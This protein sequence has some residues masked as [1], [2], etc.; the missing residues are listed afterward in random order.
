[1]QSMSLQERLNR[2]RSSRDAA[3]ERLEA[4][5]DRI[6][7]ADFVSP[8]L[9]A[10]LNAEVCDDITAKADSVKRNGKR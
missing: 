2:A 5:I 7:V 10:K 8:D 4:E 9:L 3:V 6:T 1:M